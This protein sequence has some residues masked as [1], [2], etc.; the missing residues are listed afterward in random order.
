[1]S[2][3][4][5]SLVAHILVDDSQAVQGLAE[6]E[7]KSE[8]T[9]QQ[10][11]EAAGGS[12]GKGLQ[13]KGLAGLQG[14]SKLTSGILA[15]GGVGAGAALAS[16][17][18]S[19]MAKQ[20]VTANLSAKLGLTK[21]Q[22]AQIGAVAGKLYAD[23]YG[24]SLEQ[25]SD[26]VAAVRSNIKGM[27]T[28][29]AADLKHVTSEALSF[30]QAMGVDVGDAAVS[31]GALVNTGLAKNASQAFDLLTSAAQHAGPQMVQ[32]VLDATNEYSKHF[33]MLGIDGKQAMGILA[34]AASGGEIAIDKAGDAVKEF[35]IRATDLNDTGA[36]QSLKDLGL[37]GKRMAD[38]LLA[39]GDK[40]QHATKLI[41]DGLL[42]IEDPA[43]RAKVASGLFGTQIED[44]GKDNIPKFLK[45]LASS[46]G[47]LDHVAGA[48]DRMSNTLSDTASAKLEKFKRTVQ[49]AT[50]SAGTQVLGL[51]DKWDSLSAGTQTN[52]VKMVGSLAAIGVGGVAVSKVI[53]GGKKISEMTKGWGLA[54]GPI[55]ALRELRNGA[56]E[57]GNKL[58]GIGKVGRGLQ[59]GIPLA[60]IAIAGVTT[61]I[62][63][64]QKQ[65]A[66]AKERANEY[67]DAFKNIE[68]KVTD[69]KIALDDNSKSIAANQ[70]LQ[71][72]GFK[73]ANNLGLSYETVTQAALG[74]VDALRQ[75][76]DAIDK[77]KNSSN[78]GELAAAGYGHAQNTAAISADK[79]QGALGKTRVAIQQNKKDT[80]ALKAATGE[81]TDKTRQAEGATSKNT[82]ALLDMGDQ[83]QRAKTDVQQLA[84]QLFALS[85]KTIDAKSAE[86]DFKQAI[87][88]A[89]QAAKDNGATLKDGTQKG[90]DNEQQLIRL[91]QSSKAYTSKLIENGKSTKDVTKASQAGRDAFIQVAEKMGKTKTQAEH[92]ADKYGLLDKRDLKAKISTPGMKD[93]QNQVD[94]LDQKVRHLHDKPVKITYHV[95]AGG[96]EVH[97]SNGA[98]AKLAGGG[99]VH[100]PGTR[101]SDSIPI[102]ASDD[103]HMWSAREVDGAGG[104]QSVARL[105]R[106]A[107][108]GELR[109]LLHRAN[110]GPITRNISLD[111]QMPAA[112]GPLGGWLGAT[113]QIIQQSVGKG[114]KDALASGLAGPGGGAI[115][116][117]GSN[118]VNWH[119][120]RFTENFAN[121]LQNA[122]RMAQFSVFQGGWNPGG[123][124]ASGTTH[125][126]DAVDA[127]PAT[128]AVQN[129]LRANGLAAWIR[130]PAEGFIYHIHGV[131]LPGAGTPSPQAAWQAQDFLRGGNGLLNGTRW[132]SAGI[133]AMS[134]DGRPELVVGPQYRRLQTGSR[135]FNGDETEQLMT[136]GDTYTILALDPYQTGRV[137]EDVLTKHGRAT[138]GVIVKQRAGI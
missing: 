63:F 27:N 123:V 110:G 86:L 121:H 30:A 106:M 11:G 29:S 83:A 4:L 91:A 5:G 6:F 85:D 10:S 124:A 127:G 70:L 125:D 104:H 95:T 129:A 48:A 32:P 22:S 131:P 103:E 58:S 82:K 53:A 65:A 19:A 3:D 78:D 102:M 73:A 9:G 35:G 46:K 31:A 37:S 71:L 112:A 100:G 14:F 80:N 42:G 7:K 15:A 41:T 69:A 132:A 75:V 134:E 87:H 89:T 12:F 24:D 38:D 34:T 40:A 57:A 99:P 20:D 116:L 76:N 98:V 60:G 66:E 74:N 36:Q 62:A 45:A 54:G 51:V 64:F 47:G 114:V 130:T 101:T 16:G 25:V 88:D 28:A 23:N 43:T 21:Q 118:L 17:I 92:L 97:F 128:L 136:R 59:I 18:S 111:T 44:I 94:K 50:T 39:G 68:G 115:P 137:L 109:N 135:V 96:S 122:Y 2:L 8:Q 56:D 113:S 138:T 93:A 126:K 107:R 77:A 52:V 33:A 49:A 55:S 26:G 84:S 13:S 119:G 1:M 81:N 67:A 117:G 105:R 72:G 61:A 79:L 133:H 120:G 108:D 90:R